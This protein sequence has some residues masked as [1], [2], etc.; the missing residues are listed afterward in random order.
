MQKEEN[1]LRS[2]IIPYVF[3]WLVVISAMIHEWSG[4]RDPLATSWL[5]FAA[6]NKEVIVTNV[7]VNPHP[8]EASGDLLAVEIVGR[9][10]GEKRAISNETSKIVKLS[11]TPK[12]GERLT[13]VIRNGQ[14]LVTRSGD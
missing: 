14:V 8:Q 2:K 4:S 9:V 12:V 5:K 6:K 1:S 7:I 11:F 13:L 3:Y 10:N